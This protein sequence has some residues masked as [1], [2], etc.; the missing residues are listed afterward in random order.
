MDEMREIGERL[1]KGNR[2]LGEMNTK[3]DKLDTLDSIGSKLDTLD[4]IGSK[5]DTLPERIAQALR[6]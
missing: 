6:K 1:D 4:P 2:I 5:L 3:L